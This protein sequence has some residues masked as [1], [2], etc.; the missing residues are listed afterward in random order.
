MFAVRF[1]LIRA[2]KS[3]AL[4]NICFSIDVG[5]DMLAVVQLAS[6]NEKK[7]NLDKTVCLITEAAAEG[8]KMVFLPESADFIATSGKEVV[9][10]SEDFNGPFLTTISN[11]AKQLDIWISVGSMHRK[12]GDHRLFNTHVVLN[13]KGEIVG[14]YDKTHLFSNE[15]RR[16]SFQESR[17]IQPGFEAPVV[18]HGTPVGDLG[19]AICYDLRFPELASALRYRGGANVL[20]YPSAFT[21]TTGN[22]GHWHTLLRARAIENQC[23]VIA[24]AQS[25]IHNSKLTTYGHSMVVDPFGQIIAEQMKPGPGLLF[26]RLYHHSRVRAVLP[27]EYSRRH[28]LFPHSIFKCS[29][30]GTDEFH[31]GPFVVKPGQVF[32][33]TPVSIAFVNISPLVPG[34]VLVTP[35]E[36]IDRFTLLPIGTI[37]DMYV[38][39]ERIA[40]KLSEQYNAQSFT[41]SIQ[42]GKDAGQTVP[43]VHIHVLPRKPGDFAK[44]DDI[45]DALQNHDKVANR[46]Y[47][48]Y[49]EMAEE[50]KL[51]RSLF[52]DEEGHP[53]KKV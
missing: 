15:P 25:A 28:D 7:K 23:Y 41:I 24:A 16:M 26:A 18:V 30:I 13:G 48:S 45:Y 34:H 38:C 11:L 52:Y 51:L 31:F 1:L 4:R 40:N 27:V 53:L 6:T 32:Y 14:T 35:I 43:H 20:A 2:L 12:V 37:T 44:N 10:L 29:A 3:T 22:A 9:D 5:T 39:V 33:R 46:K 49:E 21:S 8:A 47:R 42:D 50:A 19:L 36:T 17:Y